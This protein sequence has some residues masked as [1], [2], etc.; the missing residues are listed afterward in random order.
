MI[1]LLSLVVHQA[2]QSRKFLSS[3]KTKHGIICPDCNHEIAHV[4]PS[5]PSIP[6]SSLQQPTPSSTL[7]NTVYFPPQFASQ[8]NRIPAQSPFAAHGNLP[9]DLAVSFRPTTQPP[10]DDSAILPTFMSHFTQPYAPI[11]VPPLAVASKSGNSSSFPLFSP[12]RSSRPINPQR[13]LSPSYLGKRNPTD[14]D[15]GSESKK[16]PWCGPQSSQSHAT[17]SVY[18]P[19]LDVSSLPFSTDSVSRTLQ[20]S[21]ASKPVLMADYPSIEKQEIAPNWS[22]TYNQKVQKAVDVRLVRA[23]H[24]DQNFRVYCLKF[25]RDG[26]YLAVGFDRNGATTIYD[27]QTGKKSWLVCFLKF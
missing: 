24:V 23:L 10:P 11:S 17:F 6:L 7:S 27:V 25:S 1:S 16:A 26:K 9:Y 13:N 3:L 20:S 4:C 12:P 2:N 8:N 22:I 21:S 5:H 15:C 14:L 19:S 18:P